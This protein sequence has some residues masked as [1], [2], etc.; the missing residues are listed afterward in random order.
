[1]RARQCRI[2]NVDL[3]QDVLVGLLTVIR[4]DGHTLRC[5]DIE[6]CHLP[7]C[8]RRRRRCRG[9]T[10]H[11]GTKHLFHAAG[12]TKGPQQ[13]EALGTKFVSSYDRLEEGKV[14]LTPKY[15]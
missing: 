10:G 1:M 11:H 3:L 6:T 4:R 15:R 9:P 13:H 5:V 14:G 12:M 2:R 7:E 8:A